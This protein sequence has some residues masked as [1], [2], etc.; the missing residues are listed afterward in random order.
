[1]R[2]E[3]TESV[4]RRLAAVFPGA[5]LLRTRCKCTVYT[6]TPGQ[7]CAPLCWV[8]PCKRCIRFAWVKDPQRANQLYAEL[9]A[10][11]RQLRE[12]LT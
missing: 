6:A 8:E 4:R 9:A 10:H 11:I 7:G 1:M 3:I 12:S 2:T 5:F